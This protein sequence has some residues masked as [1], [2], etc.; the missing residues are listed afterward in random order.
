MNEE[1]E[2]ALGFLC[3]PPPQSY[4]LSY[5]NHHRHR[6]QGSEGAGRGVRGHACRGVRG[7]AG[8]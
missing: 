6:K 5:N 3:I 8:E 2:N 4:S 7:H 1:N